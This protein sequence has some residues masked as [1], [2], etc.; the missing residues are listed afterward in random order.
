MTGMIAALVILPILLRT[1]RFCQKKSDVIHLSIVAHQRK[2]CFNIKGKQNF[3]GKDE[4]KR[5]IATP[6]ASGEIDV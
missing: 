3:W 1:S 4:K 2:M 5:Q 6:E